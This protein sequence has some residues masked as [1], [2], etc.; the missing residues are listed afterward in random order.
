MINPEKIKFLDHHLCHAA[1]TFYASEFDKALVFTVDGKW[2]KKN[3][4]VEWLAEGQNIQKIRSHDLPH[5]LGG[6]YGTFT[7][8]LGFDR[9]QKKAS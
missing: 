7:E 8:F 3:C 5:T 4:T 2:R 1:S 6:Y 9:I